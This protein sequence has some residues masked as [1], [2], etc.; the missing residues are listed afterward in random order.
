MSHKIHYLLFIPL[1][2]LLCAFQNGTPEPPLFR[3]WFDCVQRGEYG[4]QAD[5]AISY[6]YDGETEVTVEDYRIFG[7]DF[8]GQSQP[9]TIQ[10]GEH[11]RVQKFNVGANKAVMLK[12]I[13]FGKLHVVTLADHDEF[14]DCPPDELP[15]EVTPESTI[16]TTGSV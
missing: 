14:P 13:L 3:V 2:L 7:D 6:R 11:L 8:G 10:P 12:V 15:L 16:E 1:A 4:G 9:L 5:A